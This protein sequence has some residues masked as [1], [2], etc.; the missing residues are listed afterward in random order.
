MTRDRIL[1][2]RNGRSRQ[3]RQALLAAARGL[4]EE[5]GFDALSLADVATHAGVSRMTAYLHFANRGELVIALFD[6]NA[7][8][9]GLSESMAM[10]WA[11][12]DAVAALD[13]WG[14]HLARYHPRLMAVD[15]AIESARRVDDDVAALRERVVAAKLA[16]CRRLVRW[17][18]D[19]GRL[20]AEWSRRSATDMLFAL[21]SSDLI[22]AL[23]VDRRWSTERLA[24]HL[25]LMFRSTFV[26][27][28]G[29]GHE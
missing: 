9:E 23:T 25:G 14:A 29:G 15:R 2:P 26:A 11:S 4:L 6:Y 8:L 24:E 10:V 16:N 20:R 27:D 21:I 19:E 13:E 18:A 22:E 1:E 7:T 5:R 17:L 12:P 28:V 3:T